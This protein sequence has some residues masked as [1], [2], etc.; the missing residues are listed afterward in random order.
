[1]ITSKMRKYLESIKNGEQKSVKHCVYI[2]RMQK[3]ITRELSQ[4]LWLCIH[5][6]EI[7]L[8]EEREYKD[9]TGKIQSHRRL[10][11][12]LL[13]VKALN[14]KIEVELVLKNLEF[15]EEE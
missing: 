9:E 14:P 2:N 12:L 15:P 4:L 6:P 8:D 1:M 13:C 3:R 11:K 7:F 5:H 10:K